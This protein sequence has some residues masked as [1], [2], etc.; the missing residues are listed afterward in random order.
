MLITVLSLFQILQVWGKKILPQ[1][2]DT[3]G[4][5]EKKGTLN[6]IFLLNIKPHYLKYNCFCIIENLVRIREFQDPTQTQK[7]RI[8]ILSRFPRDL[9]VFDKCRKQNII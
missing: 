8:G 6:S 1:I 9:Y 7:I 5:N 3:N 4:H 2:F